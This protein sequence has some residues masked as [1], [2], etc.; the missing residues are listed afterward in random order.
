MAL[1]PIGGAYPSE[2]AP[3]IAA[4]N[5]KVL[6]ASTAEGVVRNTYVSTADPSGGNDGDVWIKY[7]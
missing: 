6:T 2:G 4:N 7:A 1:K 5:G 3:K